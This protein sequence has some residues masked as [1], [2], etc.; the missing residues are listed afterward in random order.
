MNIRTKAI[1]T[2]CSL[3]LGLLILKDTY[4][5]NVLAITAALLFPVANLGLFL[6]ARKME[7][8]STPD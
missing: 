1:V 8:K 5:P 4:P 7:H 6:K 2:N 3:V